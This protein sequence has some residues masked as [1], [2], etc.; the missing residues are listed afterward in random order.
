MIAQLRKAIKFVMRSSKYKIQ[1]TE[2][3]MKRNGFV[4]IYLYGLNV[5]V[6][7]LNNI[8]A[9]V[10]YFM[11]KADKLKN[12]RSFQCSNHTIVS[13]AF[14]RYSLRLMNLENNFDSKE[15]T[16]FDF[17]AQKW[18]IITMMMNWC[19]TMMDAFKFILTVHVQTMADRMLPLDLA[20]FSTLI[21]HRKFCLRLFISR[22]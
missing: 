15:A 19:T 9:Y 1:E 14:E 12:G 8:S 18:D 13:E 20:L 16:N 3:N 6:L 21:I 17:V 22:F 11:E 10:V 5:F 7:L 4:C 2:W